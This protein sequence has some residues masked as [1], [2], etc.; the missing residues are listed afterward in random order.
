M[1]PGSTPTQWSLAKAYRDGAG[2]YIRPIRKPVPGSVRVAVGGVELALAAFTANST[3]G[4]VTTLTFQDG[5]AQLTVKVGD[6]FLTGITLSQIT[7][8]R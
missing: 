5:Q 6:Q 7:L 8:V 4:V 1:L 2:A 3:T